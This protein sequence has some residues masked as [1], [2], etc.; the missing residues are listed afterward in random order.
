MPRK[1]FARRQ[2]HE[3]EAA[4]IIVDDAIARAEIEHHM[5]MRCEFAA[6]NVELADFLLRRARPDRNEPTC[7]DA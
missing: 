6:W 2:I 4:R 1:R 3:A 7:R 5:I